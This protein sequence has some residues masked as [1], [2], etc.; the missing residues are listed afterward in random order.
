MVIRSFND[1]EYNPG[2][3]DVVR[4][5]DARLQIQEGSFDSNSNVAIIQ[6]LITS[7]RTTTRPTTITTPLVSLSFRQPI[8]EPTQ[9]ISITTKVTKSS[10]VQPRRGEML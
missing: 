8:T 9:L 1:F 2:S 4:L 6:A 3:I 7:G 10:I 5:N